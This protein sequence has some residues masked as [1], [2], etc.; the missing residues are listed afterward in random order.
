[1]HGGEAL[2][3]YQT[4]RSEVQDRNREKTITSTS[5]AITQSDFDKM[6]TEIVLHAMVPMRI[7]FYPNFHYFLYR[8]ICL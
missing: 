7:I 1:M 8:V 5:M 4:Y 3:E 2:K 6:I